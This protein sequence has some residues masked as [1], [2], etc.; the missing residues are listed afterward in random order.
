MRVE[1]DRD[2]WTWTTARRWPGPRGAGGRLRLRVGGPLQ[3]EQLA[4][5]L[6]ARWGLFSRWY[7]A[8]A[9]APVDHPEWPLQGAE[10]LDLSDDL[11]AA[12]GLEVTGPPPSVLFTPGVP[13]RIG[14]PVR[15]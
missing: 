11:V 15:L 6:T 8:T 12:A 5:F 10:L 3:D 1:R 7:G 2:T 9:Y 14:R 4:L 13:V